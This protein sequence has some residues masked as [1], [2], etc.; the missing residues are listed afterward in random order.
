CLP[1]YSENR[2]PLMVD[3]TTAE[4]EGEIT[5]PPTVPVRFY[6]LVAPKG[7]P[8]VND[9]SVQPYLEYDDTRLF[10]PIRP[11]GATSAKDVVEGNAISPELE[12]V[13]DKEDTTL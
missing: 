10:L 4:N 7:T 8:V 2:N 3:A 5:V 9:A 1:P 6:R 11:Q 12:T 13:V